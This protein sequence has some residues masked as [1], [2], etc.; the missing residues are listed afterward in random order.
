MQELV[1]IIEASTSAGSIA[2]V[3]D[4]MLAAQEVVA[5][6]DT[7]GTRTEGLVPAIARGLH[8]ASFSPRDI[9]SIVCGSGPGGFT[10]LR[11]AAAI[12][13]GMCSALHVPLY[14]VGT[15]ELL[16]AAAELPNGR[17]LAA[18]DAGR[19]EYY[20]ALVTHTAD[21]GAIMEPMLIVS[22]GALQETARREHATLVGP[23]L[24]IDV[25]PTAAG[26]IPLLDRIFAHGPVDL[27]TW[28]PA[29]GRPA[30]AQVKWEAEHGRPLAP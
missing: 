19:G 3:A 28:E 6:R 2:L 15:L 13:K 17:Y 27:D 1:L 23:H 9:T 22:H 8:G 4:D 18:L 30:E 11:S 5:S 12:A 16:V 29:Y 21:R 25:V 7:N 24:E 14:T 20:A 10:S 26:A